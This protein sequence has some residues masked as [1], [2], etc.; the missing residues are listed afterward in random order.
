MRC[1]LILAA[2]IGASPGIGFY[3]T[4]LSVTGALST[5]LPNI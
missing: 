2:I 5:L 1:N 3:G 4:G